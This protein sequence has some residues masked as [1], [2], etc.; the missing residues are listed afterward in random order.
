MRCDGACVETAEGPFCALSDAPDPSCPEPDE[1]EAPESACAGEE[2]IT[3]RQR[4]AM[5]RGPCGGTKVCVSN[6][7]GTPSCALSATPD[8][9]CP[10]DEDGASAVCAGDTVL[11]CSGGFARSE[12]RCVEQCVT[13]DGGFTTCMD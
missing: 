3:C 13:L 4:F 11:G 2:I 7:F 8:P 9:R 1:F 10:S 6:E 5:D 12:R